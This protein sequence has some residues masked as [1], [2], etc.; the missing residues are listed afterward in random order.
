MAL[1]GFEGFDE[2]HDNDVGAP[3]GSGITNAWPDA[4]SILVDAGELGG[5]Q[6]LSSVGSTGKLLLGTSYITII[7]GVR[8]KTHTSFATTTGVLRFLDGSTVHC[9]VSINTSGKLFVWQGTTATVLGTGTQVLATGSHYYIEAKVTIDDTGGV[10]IVRVDEITDI[11]LSTQDTRNGGNAT[12]DTID[13]VINTGTGQRI[14]DIYVCDTTGSSPTN[15]FLGR[16]RVETLFVTTDNAVAFTPLSSTNASNVDEV[17][18]DSDTTYNSSASTGQVDTFNHGSLSSTPSTVHAA[19]VSATMRK[20]DA[21]VQ[22]VRTKL[23][24]GATTSNGTSQSPATAYQRVQ[25][26]YLTDPNDGAWTAT[27]IN[28]TKIGY[29]HV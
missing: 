22:T 17:Q 3:F 16:I 15:T 7:C 10:A 1:I 8:Y 14:D 9:G 11:N 28:A 20:D 19:I 12:L 21:T 13:F 4:A 29:E 2:W 26:M 5:Q 23:I 25:N 6:A 18:M 24:S 27:T